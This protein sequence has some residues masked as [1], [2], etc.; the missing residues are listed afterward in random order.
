MFEEVLWL[1][2]K[3]KHI[4]WAFHLKVKMWGTLK[5]ISDM[6]F[7]EWGGQESCLKMTFVDFIQVREYIIIIIIWHMKLIYLYIKALKFSELKSMLGQSCL[8]PLVGLRPL[9]V[10]L[11]TPVVKF[12]GKSQ[13]PPICPYFFW[14]WLEIFFCR[15]V[16]PQ[17]KNFAPRYHKIAIEIANLYTKFVSSIIGHQGVSRSSCKWSYHVR[18][19]DTVV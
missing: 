17:W 5:M 8:G 2:F 14:K 11:G 16:W 18:Q 7:V 15:I 13:K 3:Y 19:I 6:S 10:T 12:I 1:Y 4:F 9:I